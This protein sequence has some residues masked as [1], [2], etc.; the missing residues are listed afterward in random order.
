ML[1]S[2]MVSVLRMLWQY[3]LMFLKPDLLCKVLRVQHHFYLILRHWALKI[4]C[5]F[6]LNGYR[7]PLFYSH[8]NSLSSMAL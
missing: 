8:V 1:L 6:V 2:G 7:V 5:C 4:C 3:R